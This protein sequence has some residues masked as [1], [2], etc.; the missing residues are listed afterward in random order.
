MQA[1]TEERGCNDDDDDDALVLMGFE[2]PNFQWIIKSIRTEDVGYHW[3][4]W[5]VQQLTK[6]PA[7][8]SS[9]S[10]TPDKHSFTVRVSRD[11]EIMI[12]IQSRSSKNYIVF[13]YPLKWHDPS[14]PQKY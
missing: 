11:V 9:V 5:D 1:T 8:H 4:A 3:H 10:T 14:G 7:C 12:V 13:R 6:L 2:D